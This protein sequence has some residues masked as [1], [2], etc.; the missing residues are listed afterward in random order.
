MAYS[1]QAYIK[2]GSLTFSYA[3]GSVEQLILEANLLRPYVTIHIKNA[4]KNELAEDEYDFGTV[5][6]GNIN[7]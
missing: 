6:I 4:K 5:F 7:I 3:N 2:N 1:P